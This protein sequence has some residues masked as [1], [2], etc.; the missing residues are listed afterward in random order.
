MVHTLTDDVGKASQEGV[1]HSHVVLVV[2]IDIDDDCAV[3]DIDAGGGD[4]END[5]VLDYDN[6]K[7]EHD[8]YGMMRIDEIAMIM[9]MMMMGLLLL[10][11]M[12]TLLHYHL[13]HV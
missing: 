9:I 10:M 13:Q 12:M 6:A 5:V 11:M 8:D 4:D 3:M 7:M 1:V 2:V